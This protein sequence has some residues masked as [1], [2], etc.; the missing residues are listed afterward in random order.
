MCAPVVL[1]EIYIGLPVNLPHYIIPVHKQKI[2]FCYT[3][4]YKSTDVEGSFKVL[5]VSGK[6]RCQPQL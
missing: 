2:S 4:V 1:C 3:C 6:A 5:C